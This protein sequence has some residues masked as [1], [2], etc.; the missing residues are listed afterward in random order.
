[1][2]NIFDTE[3]GI[4]LLEKAKRAI[5][6][7]NMAPSLAGDVV[8]GLSGGADSVALL[9]LLLK[10][11]EAHP[12][13]LTAIHINHMIR[14]KDADNDE[15][16]CRALCEEL[17]VNFLSYKIDIPKLSIEEHRGIEETAREYRY[18]VFNEKLTEL[19]YST[20]AV[21]HNATDN[22]E[23]IILNMM[24]GTGI[25][26][27]AGIPAVRDNI[28]RPLMYLSKDEI[29]DLLDT[30][31]TKY[32]VDKTN[33]S[34]DYKRN[35]IRHKI[36]PLLNEISTNPVEMGTRISLN[37][38]CDIDYFSDEVNSFIVDNYLNEKFDAEKLAN[39]K[40]ALFIRVLAHI[41]RQKTNYSAE[42]VHYDAIYNH[43]FDK[44]FSYSL[45]GEVRFVI[46]N[47]FAYLEDDKEKEIV[48]IPTTI[49]KP[50]V[51]EISGF[52]SVI[53]ISEDKTFESYLNVYKIEITATISSDIIN[54]GLCVRSRVSGD[55]YAY[56]GI[57]RRIKK[58]FIDRKIPDEKKAL[59][60]VIY[61]NDGIVWAVGFGIRGEGEI[62]S[63]LYIAIA[64]PI[65]K[66][67]NLTN[68]FISKRK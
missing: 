48:S 43:R 46:K 18:K 1:M 8:L 33:L 21:A 66:N 15:E 40:K 45:P 16:F 17:N 26:G 24:R 22:L 52:S 11:K 36:I 49:L 25:T 50:G 7:Y 44:N 28:I 47:G 64:E 10:L 51:N 12:F 58:L 67:E 37:L 39:L 27:L 6:D 35:Y 68:F 62:S 3:K 55:S 57:K 34:I 30:T 59:V 29:T 56:G 54:N 42:K 9:Y 23:T 31:N 20:I 5:N 63:P 2:N 53:I 4:I 65:D 19:G 13:S 32:V 60:P 41:I 61:D 38:R 14:G